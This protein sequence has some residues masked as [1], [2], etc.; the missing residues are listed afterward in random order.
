MLKQLMTIIAATLISLPANAAVETGKLAP[1]FTGKTATGAE[2]SLDQFRGKNVVLEWT[3]PECP[4]V[5]KHYGGGNMQALQ[6]QVTDGGAVWLS[7]NSSADGKQGN[8]SPEQAQKVIAEKNIASTHYLLDPTGLIGS[9]YGAQT[10]P[11]IFIIN[12]EGI[13]VYQG[14]IDSI[15][16]FDA[17]DIEKADNYVSKTLAA[18][19]SGQKVDPTSTTPYGCSVKYKN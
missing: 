5:V 2:V 11:H 4:F 18:L 8:L 14:A 15:A 7:I 13:L 17:A 1:D 3:N 16:S 9:L 6:K 12:A 19:N 10:T